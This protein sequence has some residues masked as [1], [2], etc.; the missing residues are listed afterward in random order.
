[1]CAVQDAVL[2]LLERVNE[3]QR[4]A[5]MQM[6]ETD[7]NRKGAKR[8]DGQQNDDDA[9]TVFKRKYGKR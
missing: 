1:M 2:L 3:A 9:G 6:R 7:K 5:T 4:L 8:K